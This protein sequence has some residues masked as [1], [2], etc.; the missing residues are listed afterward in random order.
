M[1]TTIRPPLLY[2]VSA[3]GM[4]EYAPPLPETGTDIEGSKLVQ[5]L[6][7]QDPEALRQVYAR[8]S[9][10][11]FAYLIRALPDRASAEDVQQQ[12]F[13]EAWQKSESFD[14]ARGSLLT[15][16]M[17]IARSRA[18]DS[19]RKKVPEPRDP[20]GAGDLADA[21][22]ANV[23]GISEFVETWQFSQIVGRLPEEEAVLLRYRFQEELSQTEIAEKTGIPLGTV[24]SRMVS[25]LGRLRRMMEVEA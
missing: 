21:Q 15:W 10:P 9:K 4:I 11:V 5:R 8:Y 20:E 13:M 18:I 24:K 17:I 14:P 25:G 3:H 22:A 16:L 6:R 19:L 1:L 7:D 12:V 2:P 23:D